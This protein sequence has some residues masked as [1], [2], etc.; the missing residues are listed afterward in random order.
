M[1]YLLKNDTQDLFNHCF[2]LI[3][4][5]FRELSYIIYLLNS[6]IH[7]ENRIDVNF[8]SN[9]SKTKVTIFVY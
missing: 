7:L 5:D 8:D 1:K 4:I 9:L 6:I 3:F 2:L